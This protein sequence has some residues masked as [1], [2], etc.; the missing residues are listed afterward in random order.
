LTRQFT[1]K[2]HLDMQVGEQRIA[3]AFTP[4]TRTRFATSNL[5]YLVGRHY[6]LGAGWTVYH[7]GLQNYD[8]TF[9]TLGFR[10]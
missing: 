2:L 7:G 3:S 10:F 5:D 9:V 8:Q 6:I 4:Q 1:D